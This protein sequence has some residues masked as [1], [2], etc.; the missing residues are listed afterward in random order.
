MNLSSR[1]KD[2]VFDETIKMLAGATNAPTQD[3][4]NVLPLYG[5]ENAAGIKNVHADVVFY[6][7]TY[8][9]DPNNKQMDVTTN[10][11]IDPTLATYKTK[12]NRTMR[13]NWVFCGDDSMEWADTLRLML[14]DLSIRTDFA[15]Q[16]MSLIPD[17]EEALFVPEIIGQKWLHRYDLYADFN[18]LVTNQTTIPAIAKADV[19]IESE[20]GVE[21]ICSV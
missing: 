2:F 9:G 17:V 4:Q 3:K 15:A 19:I 11:N 8:R 14:F 21:A 1:L 7:I 10:S 5:P 18:Q 13:I 12:Y 20:K 6:N 16:G